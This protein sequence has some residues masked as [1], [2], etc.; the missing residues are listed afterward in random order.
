MLPIIAEMWA[1]N[2][3][4]KKGHGDF[5]RDDTGAIYQSR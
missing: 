2:H 5:H 4:Y 1:K 3:S